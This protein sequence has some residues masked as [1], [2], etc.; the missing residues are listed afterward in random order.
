MDPTTQLNLE[1]EGSDILLP[2]RAQPKS[3]KNQIDGIHDGR[4]KVCVTQ[5]P[6]KGKANKALLKVI[7]EGLQLKRSQIELY[8]GETTALK[9]FR[10]SEI[11]LDELRQRVAEALN[12]SA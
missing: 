5:A 11:S 3:S 6:E 9:V 8:K 7:K 10:I 1:I 12:P 4:L 2:V